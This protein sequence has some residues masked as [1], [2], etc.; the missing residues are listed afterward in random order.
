MFT[1]CM[2]M[3]E[4]RIDVLCLQETRAAKA[5]YFVCDGFYVILSGPED[6]GKNFAGV[7]FVVAPWCSRRIHG[8]FQYSDRVA[9]LRL[10]GGPGKVAVVCAYAPHNLKP[11]DE[12]QQFYVDLGKVCDKVSCNGPTY[13]LG[14]FNA[15][16]GNRR[17]G[18]EDI[19][20]NYSFGREAVHVVETPNRELLLE[21]C[22]S[23]GLVVANTLL[24]TLPEQKVTFVSAG[25]AP[26]APPS[27]RS[28]AMLDL[29]LL[30]ATEEESV[31]TV[32]SVRE[33]TIASDHFLLFCKVKC[34]THALPTPKPVKKDRQILQQP[35]V[36]QSFVRSFAETSRNIDWDDAG[37]CVERAWES[38][39][40]SFSVAAAV[41]PEA[42]KRPRRPWISEETFSLIGQRAEAR[43]AGDFTLE[44][45]LHKMVRR[46]AKHDKGRW[47]EAQVASGSWESI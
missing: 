37:D 29:L 24:Q 17:P 20:G 44:K 12:R 46:A 39:N 35:K 8:F 42:L 43:T 38:L 11:H 1:V 32:L 14:D 4:Y 28:F 36:R 19:M 45:T 18:E 27:E 40:G 41:L 7:G 47:L 3:R 25:V 9:S 6:T 26:S 34:E 33:A 13:L 30:P 21:F 15:R 5:E 22:I 2:Y 16:L 23:R 10:R 31:S